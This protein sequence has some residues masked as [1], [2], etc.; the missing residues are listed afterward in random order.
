MSLRTLVWVTIA[1]IAWRGILR[2]QQAVPE[3]SR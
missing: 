1:T 2:R 3:G